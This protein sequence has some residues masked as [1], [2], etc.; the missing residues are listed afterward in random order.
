MYIISY[1]WS[2]EVRVCSSCVYCTFL[3]IVAQISLR[4]HTPAQNCTRRIEEA[5]VES[6]KTLATQRIQREYAE[7]L[8]MWYA[9]YVHVE[10]SSSVFRAISV[11]SAENVRLSPALFA[12]IRNIIIRSKE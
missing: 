7:S 9:I 8:D 1:R 11:T 4:S 3:P 10:A 5:R 12:N 6:V 2:G